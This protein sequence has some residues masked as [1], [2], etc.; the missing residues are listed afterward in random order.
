MSWGRQLNSPLKTIWTKG[1]KEMFP[2]RKTQTD[3]NNHRW[4][5]FLVPDTSAEESDDHNLAFT[6]CPSKS[7]A[8]YMA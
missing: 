8:V 5:C 4:L 6:K 1:E 3:Q 2:R 7:L